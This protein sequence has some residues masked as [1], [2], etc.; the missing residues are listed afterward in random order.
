MRGKVARRRIT[1][2]RFGITPAYAGKSAI[3]SER[4]ALPRDHPRLCG[5]KVHFPECHKLFHGITP[6]YAGKSP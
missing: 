2:F 1:P 5:E 3:A 4:V 6:A